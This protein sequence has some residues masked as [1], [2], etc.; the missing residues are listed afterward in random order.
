MAVEPPLFFSILSP[1]FIVYNKKINKGSE[2]PYL[3]RMGGY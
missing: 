2:D 1:Y 3:Y